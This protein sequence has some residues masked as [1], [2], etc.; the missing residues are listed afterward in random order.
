MA[1]LTPTAH[2]TT[3]VGFTPESS[4]RGTFG[5]LNPCLAVLFLNTWTVFHVNIPSERLLRSRRRWWLHRLKIWIITIIVPDGISTVAFNQ[6]REA[7]RS[8]RTIQPIYAWWTIKH[9]FYAEMGGF[10]VVDDSSGQEYAFRAAQL[11]WLLARQELELPE[12]SQEELDDKSDADWIAKTIACGQS[13]WFLINAM[14]RLSS[15]MPLTTL[16]IEVL[17]FIA[18]TWWTYLFWWQKPVNILLPTKVHVLKLEEATLID[19]ARE[20]CHPEQGPA[21]WR[22]VPREI[23]ERGWDFYWFEKPLDTNTW[24]G[25]STLDAMPTNLK[26]LVKG[27]PAQSKVEVWYRPAVNEMHP[28]EWTWLDDLIIYLLGMF[29]NAALLGAWEFHFPSELESKLW[30]AAV[31]TMMGSITLWWPLA[32]LLRFWL[33][34]T[35][36]AKHSAFYALMGVYM[37]GRVYVIFEP[38]VG[39]RL[40]PAN[41]YRAVSWSIFVA[42]IG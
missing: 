22:P 36:L 8:I 27:T 38:F 42:H 18:T 10:R 33:R 29:I 30:K 5:I 7:R 3:L 12:V 15:G 35:S 23:H 17:P 31:V 19:L 39:L 16:E 2:N 34:P 41:A 26:R 20:T 13:L 40:L 24:R 32:W 25:V 28:S 21:W 9:G 14:A 4:D 6:W 37:A 11:S 1:P